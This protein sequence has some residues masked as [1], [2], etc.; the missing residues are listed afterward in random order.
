[1]IS[2]KFFCQSLTELDIDFYTG[3]PDSLL[4]DICAYVT[5]KFPNEKH[6]ITA[7]EGS[8][9]GLAIGYYISS[10]KLALVYMQNSGLGNA[11]NPILSLADKQIYSIPLMQNKVSSLKSFYVLWMYHML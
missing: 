10:K 8:A 5:S 9:I 7:N 11:V 3:V 6:K 1:M 2:P 4:K